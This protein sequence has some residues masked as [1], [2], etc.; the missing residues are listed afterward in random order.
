MLQF[1]D[2]MENIHKHIRGTTMDSP[3]SVVI[4]EIVMQEIENLVLPQTKDKIKFCFHY[5]DD[6]IPSVQGTK[7]Q[8][9]LRIIKC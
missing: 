5:E 3:V 8:Q 4:A 9:V 2:L 7:A 6:I 1:L